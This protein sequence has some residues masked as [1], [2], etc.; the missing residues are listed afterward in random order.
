MKKSIRLLCLILCMALLFTGCAYSKA[1]KLYGYEAY[2]DAAR[3]LEGKTSKR[4]VALYNKARYGEA[5]DLF[6]QERFQEAREIFL[7]QLEMGEAELFL[8]TICMIQYRQAIELLEA[9]ELEEAE[10]L[11]VQLDDYLDA[12]DYANGMKWDYLLRYLKEN[13]QV[14]IPI[15]PDVPDNGAIKVLRSDGDIL[16]VLR[17]SKVDTVDLR[18]SIRFERNEPVTTFRYDLEMTAAGRFFTSYNYL[19]WDMTEDPLHM[20]NTWDKTAI[21]DSYNMLRRMNMDPDGEIYIQLANDIEE[22]LAQTGL[23]MTAQDLGITLWPETEG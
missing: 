15:D 6:G 2:D 17:I 4:A 14:E 1:K 21:E 11:F 10:A 8:D 22:L 3:M 18:Y 12:P 7:E 23:D 9:G 5:V 19:K 16:E 20:P 13:G